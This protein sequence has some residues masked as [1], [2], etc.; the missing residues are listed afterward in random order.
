MTLTV[1]NTAKRVHRTSAA[2]STLMNSSTR[3]R[4][5][6]SAPSHLWWIRVPTK[7][8]QQSRVRSLRTGTGRYINANRDIC[9]QKKKVRMDKNWR[10]RRALMRLT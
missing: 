5:E 1:K 6:P 7:K 9:S 4:L 2:A 8:P 3:V 10:I